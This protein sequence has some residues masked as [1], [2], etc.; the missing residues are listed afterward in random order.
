[1]SDQCAF[2]DGLINWPPIDDEGREVAATYATE[3]GEGFITGRLIKVDEITDEG[4]LELPTGLPLWHIVTIG[5]EVCWHDVINF[6][7]IS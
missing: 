5:V 6:R 1:M 4:E 7:Y 3:Y 2:L